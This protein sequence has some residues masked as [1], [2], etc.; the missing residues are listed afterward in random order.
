MSYVEEV[1]FEMDI[2]IK[3]VSPESKLNMTVTIFK[4][5]NC[6]QSSYYQKCPNSRNCIDKNLFC[7][8]L[9]NCHFWSQ[10]SQL[11][12]ESYCLEKLQ[13]ESSWI[14]SNIPLFIVILVSSFCLI[15]LA[16]IFAYRIFLKQNEVI[17]ENYFENNE[18]TQLPKTDNQEFDP[19]PSYEE[20]TKSV[21]RNL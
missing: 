15:C 14:H 10:N 11:T 21:H 16:A 2:W 1:D 7:D 4:K 12:D 9:V 6:D 3:T 8:G 5:F 17:E 20:A 18:L 19:P 13:E